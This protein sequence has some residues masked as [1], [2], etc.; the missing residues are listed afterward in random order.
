[1]LMDIQEDQLR[2]LVDSILKFPE[3]INRSQ[4]QTGFFRYELGLC[5][6]WCNV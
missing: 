2:E 3:Q 5:E 4:R 6:A 1:M